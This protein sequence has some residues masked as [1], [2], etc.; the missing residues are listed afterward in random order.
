MIGQISDIFYY[1]CVLNKLN[2]IQ[3]NF[4]ELTQPPLPEWE[5]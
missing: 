2:K 4:T 5:S 1:K 3:E